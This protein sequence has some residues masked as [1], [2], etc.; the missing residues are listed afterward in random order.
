MKVIKNK[1]IEKMTGS[2]TKTDFGT[3]TENYHCM[4]EMNQLFKDKYN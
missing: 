4:K 1:K 2:E 3:N